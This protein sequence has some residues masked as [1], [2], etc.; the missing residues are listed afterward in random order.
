MNEELKA[1]DICEHT[2]FKGMYVR[3]EGHVQEKLEKLAIDV[4]VWES[5][6]LDWGT[7]NHEVGDKRKIRIS[8]FCLKK[9]DHLKPSFSGNK[10]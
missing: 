9:A 1:G 8:T 3:I 7:F 5:T 10:S 6:V 4:D 2:G